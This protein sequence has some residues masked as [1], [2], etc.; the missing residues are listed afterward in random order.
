MKSECRESY[1]KEFG[2]SKAYSTSPNRENLL[3][4][5]PFKQNTTALEICNGRGI[6]EGGLHNNFSRVVSVSSLED[7]WIGPS[8]KIEKFDYII[9]SDVLFETTK[10]ADVLLNQIEQIKKDDAIVLIAAFNPIG[11]KYLSGAIS[12]LTGCNGDAFGTE[13]GLKRE[14]W[15]Q[16]IES[17]GWRIN[18]WYYPYP[19]H[20]FPTE[21]FSD[22]SIQ[23]ME[24]GRQYPNYCEERLSYWGEN[25]FYK[26]IPSSMRREFANSFLIEIGADNG[27]Q[28]YYAKLNRDRK[29]EFQIGTKIEYR[30]EI[31][32]DTRWVSK[33][34]LTDG[35]KD[36]IVNM[37]NAEMELQYEQISA[38]QSKIV[39]D[40]AEYE[41]L[42]LPSFDFL[43]SRYLKENRKE[44]IKPLIQ[45]F[46]EA[47]FKQSGAKKTSYYNDEF[48]LFFGEELVVDNLSDE[49]CVSPANIDLIAANIYCDGDQYR[50]IDNE[51]ILHTYVPARFLIWRCINELYYVHTQLEEVL[52]CESLLNEFGISSEWNAQ[53][54]KWNY[55]FTVHYIGTNQLKENYFPVKRIEFVKKTGFLSKLYLDDGDGFSEAKVIEGTLDIIH[56]T[57]EVSYD[58][59]EYDNIKEIRWDPL[60]DIACGTKI[61]CYFDDNQVAIQPGINGYYQDGYDWFFDGDPYYQCTVDTEISS[62][63]I[64]GEII[65]PDIKE[66][67]DISAKAYSQVRDQLK[68]KS[69]TL[70][71]I[72]G[73]RSW[74]LI[75]HVKKLK[76][77]FGGNKE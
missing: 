39:N 1:N 38:L 16:L 48:K 70:E 46:F 76:N 56:H 17:R 9:L 23:E 64:T 52:S 15:E 8:K 30:K 19:D 33:F 44:E 69:D 71:L 61:N 50:I 35:A 31:S 65:I 42:N 27:N 3:S 62:V 24:Y 7:E 22:A 54:Q 77:F 51:W 6:L 72:Y 75:Q 2:F 11:A 34:P 5:Y 68:Q 67:Q 74:K 55:Y 58:V 60:A 14:Q 66:L 32:K 13:H 4:W 20:I 12:P 26:A 43:I 57:F 36:H 45:S 47:Y 25:E 37:H 28:V 21:I 18:N 40:Q 41:F 63:R 10:E 29:P 53:Y 73:S 59:S 49:L